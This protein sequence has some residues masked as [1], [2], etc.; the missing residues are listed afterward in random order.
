MTLICCCSLAGTPACKNC[1]RYIKEF[2]SEKVN[3]QPPIFY[4]QTTPNQCQHC[5]CQHKEV[6]GVK[7]K[8]C[9]MCGHQMAET[10]L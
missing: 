2:G 4:P 8:V 3:Y 9:C 5:Y 6:N 10:I 7:H 1:P